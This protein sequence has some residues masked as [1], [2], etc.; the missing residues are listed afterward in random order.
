MLAEMVPWFIAPTEVKRV[1]TKA[2][3]SHRLFMS[4]FFTFTNDCK[5]FIIAIKD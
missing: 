2:V 1:D 5:S 4:Q 3:K